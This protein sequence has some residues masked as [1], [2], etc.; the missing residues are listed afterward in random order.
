M[1]VRAQTGEALLMIH[2]LSGVSRMYAVIGLQDQEI[3]AL[4]ATMSLVYFQACSPSEKISIMVK[5]LS[6]GHKCHDQDLN[7]HSAAESICSTTEKLNWIKEFYCTLSGY[8]L[9]GGVESLKS[10]NKKYTNSARLFSLKH[11]LFCYLEK[12][13]GSGHFW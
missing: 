10:R 2:L 6:K 8:V 12:L 5:C 11:L 1:N 13:K 7:P 4:K 3:K 9:L